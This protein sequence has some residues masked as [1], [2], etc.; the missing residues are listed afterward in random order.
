M[1]PETNKLLVR[2]F[3]ATIMNAGQLDRLDQFVARDIIDHNAGPDQAPGIVGYQQHLIGVRTTFPDFTLTI[4][5][6]FAEGAYVITRVT[7]R[8]THQG[9][10]L[11]ITPRGTAITVTGINLDCVVDGKIVEHWG[12]ANT[13]GMLQ[14]LGV[15]LVPPDG[16]S[17]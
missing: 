6:Q 8:G 7:G 3:I 13:V 2:Q 11:G 1:S 10:W 12:E 14:Q 15:R 9:A 5:A 17:A 4:E 16:L